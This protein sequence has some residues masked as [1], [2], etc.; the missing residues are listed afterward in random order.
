M[1]RANSNVLSVPDTETPNSELETKVVGSEHLE[2]PPKSEIIRTENSKEIVSPESGQPNSEG[3]PKLDHYPDSTTT[4]TAADKTSNSDHLSKDEQ[5]T[6]EQ[7]HENTVT[8]HENEKGS[9]EEIVQDAKHEGVDIDNVVH[10]GNN[11]DSEV[12]GGINVGILDDKESRN[13]DIVK[14]Q[15]G[16]AQ[17]QHSGKLEVS[18]KDNECSP[19]TPNT[20]G[21]DGASVDT[22]A[23]IEED[24]GS[25][26]LKVEFEEVG[27]N[28]RLDT[29]GQDTSFE[30][31]GGISNE[32][33][34]IIKEIEERTENL[35]IGEHQENQNIL[36]VNDVAMNTDQSEI[37]KSEE[38]ATLSPQVTS[39]AATV[40]P[41][42]TSTAATVSPQVTSAAATVSPQVTSTA[43]TVSPQVTSTAA[44]VSPLVTS[45]AATLSPQVTSTAAT[46]SPQVTSTAATVSPLVTSTAATVSPPVTST[47]EQSQSETQ[48]VLQGRSLYGHIHDIF[49]KQQGEEVIKVLCI[50]ILDTSRQH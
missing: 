35:D 2:E 32:S 50:M 31:P 7:H 22:R 16:I 14:E 13:D 43:A 38:G 48:S 19:S 40:S 3:Q 12:H 26:K 45:T 21:Q 42:V 5:A 33:T 27:D 10:E 37:I 41:Q 28:V 24:A 15:L 4:S 39:T 36:G 46:V 30:L 29:E 49:G 8:G 20:L 18:H 34:E 9:E 25:H 1:M 6:L 47:A 11:A 17:D 23:Q 44:T